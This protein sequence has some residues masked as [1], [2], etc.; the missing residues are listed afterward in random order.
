[1]I[2]FEHNEFLL[3]VSSSS[4]HIG[5]WLNHFH[6]YTRLRNPEGNPNCCNCNTKKSIL[7]LTPTS[8]EYEIQ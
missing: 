3:G 1:D 4:W 5:G 2:L 7:R 8:C 6:Q